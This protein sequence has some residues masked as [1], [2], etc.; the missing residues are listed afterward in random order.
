MLESL[1]VIKL[2]I[3][4]RIKRFFIASSIESSRHIKHTARRRQGFWPDA[5]SIQ[6]A[7]VFDVFQ[8][9]CLSV[10]RVLLCEM[11]VFSL[12][13]HT[14]YSESIH[15][16]LTWTKTHQLGKFLSQRLKYLKKL[17][18]FFWLQEQNIPHFRMAS[19]KISESIT[20][21][22]IY[23]VCHFSFFTFTSTLYESQ[24]RFYRAVQ[25]I[26]VYTVQGFFSKKT[27]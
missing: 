26:T 12:Q 11:F 15:T 13:R 20:Y 3:N 27:N 4:Y 7:C 2:I 9:T 6:F 17:I 23:R 16:P 24:L 8:L 25:E 10:L 18:E 14:S 1:P 19:I 5:N 21:C 22:R